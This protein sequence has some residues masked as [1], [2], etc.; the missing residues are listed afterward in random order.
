MTVS[1]VSVPTLMSLIWQLRTEI[2]LE[3]ASKIGKEPQKRTAQLDAGNLG[4]KDHKDNVY[5]G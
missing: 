2:D 1:A 5:L 3:C 4:R